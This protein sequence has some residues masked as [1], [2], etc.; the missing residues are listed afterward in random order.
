TF[1]S[2]R[3][4]K[5]A[6]QCY[7]EGANK[8]WQEV[9]LWIGMKFWKRAKQVRKKSFC[10]PPWEKKRYRTKAKCMKISPYNV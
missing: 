3:I 2:P 4:D 7:T 10:R 6:W 1:S 8:T 5:Y 9:L